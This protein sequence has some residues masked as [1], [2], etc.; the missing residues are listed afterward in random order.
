[1][2]KREEDPKLPKR[3]IDVNFASA[4]FLVDNTS[5]TGLRWKIRPLSHFANTRSMNSFNAKH[6]GKEAG[7]IQVYKN[8]TS[9][10]RV[11]MDGVFY[12]ASRIVFAISSQKD[13][14]VYE[15]DHI[16]GNTLNN[17]TSNL[18]IATKTQNMN[19]R[20]WLKNGKTT[21]CG[22]YFFKQN[23]TWT[24]SVSLGG[25]SFYLGQYETPDEAS[26]VRLEVTNAMNQV[27]I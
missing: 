3:K 1:M 16:D 17:S 10:H 26:A 7:H 14:D 5:S 15:V 25:K 4:C 12:L 18:R 9:R 8:G 23:Q 19:N 24:A 2:E 11:S 6:L 13:P 27:A 20:R 21:P 22:V